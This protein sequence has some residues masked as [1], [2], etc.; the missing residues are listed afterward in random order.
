MF[1]FC[2][3]A[4]PTSPLSFLEWC[5]LISCSYLEAHLYFSSW[6][7]N[8]NRSSKDHLSCYFAAIR[9]SPVVI[10]TSGWGQKS[11][12][13]ANFSAVG[14]GDESEKWWGSELMGY[15]MLKCCIVGHRFPF[16]AFYQVGKSQSD[17]AWTFKV[18]GHCQDYSWGNSLDLLLWSV[19]LCF[20][21]KVSIFCS[22]CLCVLWPCCTACRCCWCEFVFS[23]L[24]RKC[25]PQRES[26]FDFLTHCWR[27]S[28]LVYPS[29]YFTNHIFT[30]LWR[31]EPGYKLMYGL[32]Q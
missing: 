16:V 12:V 21:S 24:L 32:V 28:K 15:D 31:A 10:F 25:D 26:N 2:E 27:P 8:S 20:G 22:S 30:S 17:R 11:T 23:L 14:S 13:T 19:S 4:L 5:I 9:W 29:I 1:L 3:P 18:S 7:H 6:I